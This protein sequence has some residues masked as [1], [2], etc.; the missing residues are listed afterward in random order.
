MMFKKFFE[1]VAEIFSAKS[2]AECDCCD[3]DNC[4]ISDDEL[5]K[6]AMEYGCECCKDGCLKDCN[7]EENKDCNCDCCK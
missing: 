2:T 3:C 5:E 4:E 7:C 6:E 1:K